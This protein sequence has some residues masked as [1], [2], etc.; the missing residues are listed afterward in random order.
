MEDYMR[1]AK[2]ASVKHLCFAVSTF[3]SIQFT[4][5]LYVAQRHS[6]EEW[7]EVKLAQREKMFVF[8]LSM[9]QEI[10][11][12]GI[13]VNDLCYKDKSFYNSGF[14][15]C[16][17]DTSPEGDDTLVL[18]WLNYYAKALCI[19]AG[20]YGNQ[21]TMT[22]V[23][24]QDYAA[25]LCCNIEVLKKIKEFLTGTYNQIM[26]G[27]NYLDA[28]INSFSAELTPEASANFTEEINKSNAISWAISKKVNEAVMK[29]VNRSAGKND[30]FWGI[31]NRYFKW[32][33]YSSPGVEPDSIKDRDQVDA[34]S[35]E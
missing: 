12:D 16:V 4:K 18:K 7:F 35:F 1:I 13:F 6:I 31:C 33:T 26:H 29:I 30:S 20:N 32:Y 15:M 3:F 27:D 23:M 2:D 28:T 24:I 34:L 11:K 9:L 8:D 21:D 22:S 17:N 14:C 25:M 5:M 10:Y 19:P